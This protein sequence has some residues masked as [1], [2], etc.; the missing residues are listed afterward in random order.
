MSSLFEI[1]APSINITG[2]SPIWSPNDQSLYWVDI[3]EKKIC[4]WNE[5]QKLQSWYTEE[6]AACIMRLESGNLLL[7][8]ES[9]ISV[10][11]FQHQSMTSALLMSYQHPYSGLRFNDGCVDRQGRA[12]VSSMSLKNDGSLVGSIY[13]Y[14]NHQLIPYL[15][16]LA[17]PNGMAFSPDGNTMYVSDS[18]PSV[19]KVWAFD[20]DQIN[21]VLSNQ[22]LFIDMKNYHG[23]PDGATVDV[24]GC[25]WICAIDS[26][27]IL[28]FSPEGNL[29]NTYSLPISK[30]SKCVFGGRDM[31]T[32]FVTSIQPHQAS[33]NGMDGSVFA[34]RTGFQGIV[35][36]GVKI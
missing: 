32:L 25:Y 8:Q 35:E 34:L 7:F 27:N 29:L 2:E 15:Q 31:K 6:M 20:Y 36:S 24:D 17:T 22:R 1:I 14:Q 11:K 9:Q 26:G 10:V 18:H 12:W 3:T 21:A 30:P 13:L 5:H 4:C 23:R 16:E 19:Q 28:R 33:Q